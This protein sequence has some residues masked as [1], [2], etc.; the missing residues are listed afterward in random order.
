M[1]RYLHEVVTIT[2]DCEL[3]EKG[4]CAVV[5]ELER[6][7]TSQGWQF[8]TLLFFRRPY[9]RRKVHTGADYK[10]LETVS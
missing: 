10:Y 3:G 5:I 1:S 6:S 7:G 8:M 9:D 4:E 2:R